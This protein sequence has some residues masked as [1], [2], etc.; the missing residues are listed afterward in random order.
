ML[1]QVFNIATEVDTFFLERR[2]TIL[3]TWEAPWLMVGPEYRLSFHITRSLAR[4]TP[5]LLCIPLKFPS[6][7]AE[8]RRR[9]KRDGIRRGRKEKTRRMRDLNVFMR[10]GNVE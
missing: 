3:I 5:R 8:K 2:A 6:G 9:R 1:S 7:C 10:R 4:V